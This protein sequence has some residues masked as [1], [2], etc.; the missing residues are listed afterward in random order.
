MYVLPTSGSRIQDFNI[1]Y[2]FSVYE[3]QTAD[4]TVIIIN[5]SK[6]TVQLIHR[7]W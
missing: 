5:K 1:G 7:T 2:Y 3:I 6:V 4:G